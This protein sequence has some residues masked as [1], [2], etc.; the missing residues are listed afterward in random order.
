MKTAGLTVKA[1]PDLITTMSLSGR[2]MPIIDS[3]DPSRA[4]CAPAARKAAWV[5]STARIMAA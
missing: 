5:R 2:G 1:R 4:S 3:N